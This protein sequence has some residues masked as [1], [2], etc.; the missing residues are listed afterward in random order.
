MI[1]FLFLALAIILVVVFQASF[2]T[3]VL[4]AFAPFL[5]I[6]AI[7]VVVFVGAIMLAALS[8]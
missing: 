3:G 6:I 4:V 8:K 2:A 7:F 1:F 5:F